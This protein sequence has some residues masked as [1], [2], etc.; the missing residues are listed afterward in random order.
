MAN[1]MPH[2]SEQPWNSDALNRN[3]PLKFIRS[4]YQF[5]NF[6]EPIPFIQV[7]LLNVP[8]TN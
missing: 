2:L 7:G 6:I 3:P 1:E 5:K 8:I 4:T